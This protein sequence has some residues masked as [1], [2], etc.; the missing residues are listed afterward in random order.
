MFFIFG[1][2]NDKNLSFQKLMKAKLIFLLKFPNNQTKGNLLK[3]LKQLF[4]FMLIKYIKTL[5]FSIIFS[6]LTFLSSLIFSKLFISPILISSPQPLFFFQIFT[7][8][9]HAI[10]S[11]FRA[12]MFRHIKK[13][14]F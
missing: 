3:N 6:I 14:W 1:K 7:S 10:L 11:S 2:M 12:L 13:T 5:K 4:F 8:P 9:I